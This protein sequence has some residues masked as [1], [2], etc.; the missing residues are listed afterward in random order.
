MARVLPEPDV[1]RRSSLRICLV[2]IAVVAVGTFAADFRTWSDSTG[3]FSVKA[4]YISFASGKVTLQQEDGSQVEIEVTKLS[5][6]DQKYVADERRKA[7]NPFKR[8]DKGDSPFMPKGKSAA[9]PPAPATDDPPLT[10]VHSASARPVDLGTND[11]K[12]PTSSVSQSELP[13]RGIR[14]PA[15]NS[16]FE[17][18]SGF[19]VNES[20]RMAVVGYTLDQPKPQ[21]VTRVVLIDLA[22]GQVQPPAMASGQFVPLSLSANG[23]RILMRRSEFGGGN[24]DRLEVWSLAGGVVSKSLRFVPYDDFKSGERDVVWAAYSGDRIVTQ[25]GGGKLVVWSSR[26]NLKAEYTMAV[27]GNGTPAVSTDGKLLAF[28]TGKEVGILDIAEGRMLGLRALPKENPAFPA[29]AFSPDGT[30]LA[31]AAFDRLYVWDLATGDVF[32]EFPFQGIHVAGQ[33]MWTGPDH[34]LVGGRTLFDLDKQIRLWDYSGHEQVQFAGGLCWFVVSEGDRAPGAVV[35]AKVPQASVR[36]LLAKRLAEPDFFVLKPGTAV[37]L[38]TSGLMDVGERGP[39]E[40]ALRMKLQALNCTVGNLGTI[41]L[42][43]S[44]DG[45]KEREVTY[46]TF[47]VPF[48]NKT[49][50]VKE[51]FSRVKFV[52][53]GKSAWESSASSVPGFFHLKKDQTIEQFLKESERPSYRFFETVELPKLLT[54]PSGGTPGLGQTHV[55]TLGLR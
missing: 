2:V 1:M 13:A 30:R 34:V 19:A 44:T 25:N 11:W 38:D 47:G 36:D 35:G 52:Y 27:Q 17:R 41:A 32:R 45:G 43:A 9:A 5:A 55:T 33:V 54:K 21:G 18:T 31:C 20:A 16:F 23:E 6:A 8:S 50:K 40:A 37:A 7:E 48:G 46:H 53:Q 39:V 42:T 49:H 51:Y 14:I 10:I 24:N 29:F 26:P 12:I 28:S 4:K 22:G 3:Q 15:K